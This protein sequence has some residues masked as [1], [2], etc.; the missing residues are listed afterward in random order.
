MLP[1]GGP[2]KA[3]SALDQANMLF[4][5]AG[6]KKWTIGVPVALMDG[7]IGIFDG[8]AKVFPGLQVCLCPVRAS[9]L[10]TDSS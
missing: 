2:G 10:L 5:I 6:Q 3:L 9:S 4:E 8:L 1:I 7:I